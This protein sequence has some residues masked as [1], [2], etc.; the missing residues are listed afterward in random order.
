VLRVVLAVALTAV[1][2]ATALPAVDRARVDHS[3]AALREEAERLADGIDALAAHSDAGAG[4]RWVVTLRLPDRS[5][6][7][8]GT[9]RFAVRNGTVRFRAEEG[10]S[11]VVRF[12]PRLVDGPVLRGAGRHRLAVR[13]VERRGRP[14]VVVRRLEFI[15]EEGTTPS[16]AGALAAPG[17][18]GV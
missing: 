10:R 12:G 7:H 3:D 16:H 8:S 15:P 9:A 14:A 6:G 5:W 17:G 2:L 11:G 4:A 18:P 1:L 13:L